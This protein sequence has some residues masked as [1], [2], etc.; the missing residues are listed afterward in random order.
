MTQTTR[1]VAITLILIVSAALAQQPTGSG[2]APAGA[3]PTI[4]RGDR[5]NSENA[6][7]NGCGGVIFTEAGPPVTAGN[8]PHSIVSGDFNLDGNPDLAVADAIPG[9]NN[10][11]ILLGDARGGFKPSRFDLS[12]FQ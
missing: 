1:L 6:Q 3:A 11:T 2:V 10:L 12:S 9:P 8:T 5:L 4:T 7:L